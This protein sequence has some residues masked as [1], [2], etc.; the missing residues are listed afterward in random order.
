MPRSAR[1]YGR[2]FRCA[3][4]R[5]TQ[6]GSCLGRIGAG[7]KRDPLPSV[8]DGRCSNASTKLVATNLDSRELPAEVR[9]RDG[10]LETPRHQGFQLRSAGRL[11]QSA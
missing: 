5:G 1:P 3:P 4:G 8:R 10:V 7:T 9:A 11:N 6:V 2:S